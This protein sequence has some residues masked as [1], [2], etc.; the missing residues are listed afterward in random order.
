METQQELLII[1]DIYR[2]LARCFAYP[3]DSEIEK[4]RE[5]VQGLKQMPMNYEFINALLV[6]LEPE[7]NAEELRAEFNRI[8]IKGGLT[9]T[10]SHTMQ[11]FNAVA[12]VAAFYSAFGFTPKSGETPDSIMYELEFAAILCLMSAAAKTEEEFNIT[13]EAYNSFLK[14][15]IGDFGVKFAD[16]MLEGDA[17]TFYITAASLLREFILGEMLLLPAEE[18][19]YPDDEPNPDEKEML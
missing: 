18:N 16:K 3:Q 9:I 14:D 6:A 10:E 19:A 2:L 15:H 7:L 11:K 13:Q 1:A 8:F 4:T 5:M 12:E 17:N